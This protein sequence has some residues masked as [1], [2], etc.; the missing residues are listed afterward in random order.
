MLLCSC[1]CRKEALEM[2]NDLAVKKLKNESED[3]LN[4][5][6]DCETEA[7]NS[8]FHSDENV[9]TLKRRDTLFD[10]RENLSALQYSGM[11]Y[12]KKN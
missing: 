6:T 12:K 8:M 1:V 9:S 2:L 5:N 3:H 10:S 11:Y 7:M 4:N